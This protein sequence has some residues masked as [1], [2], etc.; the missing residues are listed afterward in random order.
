MS[1]CPFKMDPR[2]HGTLKLLCVANGH[3]KT[4]TQGIKQYDTFLVCDTATLFY[5]YSSEVPAALLRNLRLLK[6]K[7]H[8]YK[9]GFF[10]ILRR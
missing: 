10:K 5:F 4:L 1:D 9:T 7:V 3:T 6:T 8:Q 2:Y